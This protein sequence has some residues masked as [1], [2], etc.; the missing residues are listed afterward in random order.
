M[1]ALASDG[2]LQRINDVWKNKLFRFHWHLRRSFPRPS[3]TVHEPVEKLPPLDFPGRFAPI[4]RPFAPPVGVFGQ[5][6][7]K[8]GQGQDSHGGQVWGHSAGASFPNCG[9]L[10]SSA[11]FSTAM[12]DGS[13][14]GGAFTIIKS[15][16]KSAVDTICF[17]PSSE[18]T[19]HPP[20]SYIVP[21][22]WNAPFWCCTQYS[23]R[24]VA[25][26]HVLP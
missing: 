23:I 6:Q 14:E 20:S 7:R 16:V 26:P 25:V 13:S 15:S 18:Q 4:E 17:S 24:F 3:L 21:S 19:A 9:F 11:A 2:L 22:Y 10:A 5:E 12:Y 8:E 1:L